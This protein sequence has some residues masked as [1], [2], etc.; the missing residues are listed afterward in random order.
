MKFKKLKV[1]N[2]NLNFLSG[3]TLLELL[4]VIAILGI[5]S[6]ALVIIINPVEYQRQSRDSKRFSDITTL[7]N[8]LALYQQQQGG[9]IS[10]SANTVYVSIPDTSASCANL[11]LPALSGGWVYS[12]VTEA[13]LKNT[14]GTGWIP[15][16]FRSLSGG[17]PINS[18]PIDPVNSIVGNNWYAYATNGT[19]YQIWAQALESVKFS[20][21][22]SSDGGTSITAY[23]RGTI[24]SLIPS[25]ATTSTASITQTS[26]AHFALGTLSSTT[27]SGSGTGASLIFSGTPYQAAIS[28]TSGLVS[29]WKMDN[30]WQDS[31]GTNHG[32]AYNGA[33]ATGTAKYGTFSGSFDGNKYVSF[34][35]APVMGGGSFS[36]EA[37]IKTASIGTR[38]QIINFGLPTVIN[39]GAWF[40]VNTSNKLEFDLS[41]TA[42]P[43]SAETIT[44]GVWHHV[45]S[46][47]NG[48]N[49]QL[50]V[51]GLAS[52]SPFTMYPNI[53]SS[54]YNGIGAR[55]DVLSWHFDGQID[56]VAV[57]NA[58]LASS[59]ISSHFNSVGYSASG[60]F[61]SSIMDS[62]Q[63][64]TFTT[65][66]YSASALAGTSVTVDIRA[67]DVLTPD[68]TWTLW[69][70]NI[71]NGGSIS[72][73]GAKRYVQYRVNFSTTDN[74]V[75][76][77]FNDVTI[78][79]SYNL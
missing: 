17:S 77:S 69:Q 74:S 75:T 52:G 22:A 56:E 59:T 5:I 54:T 36:I 13:N 32:T 66:D 42:G 28:N 60:T 49:V 44:N 68:G 1:K 24:L 53:A 40:F 27:I 70:V 79:Y 21:K 12:C 29:Y 45:A 8:A 41:N 33:S 43:S 51:D 3:F 67:G 63:S 37:W 16:N 72:A 50:Y 6:T 10:G 20:S 61:T 71:P 38:K 73:L 15:N 57:Y 64:S 19:N 65:L 30:D 47:F 2:K 55:I 76:P 34:G 23:E 62:G 46:V 9:L 78:N 7:N 39:Q 58:A 25:V 14:D 4:I 31:K 11:G 26:D 48:S 35:A 18:L